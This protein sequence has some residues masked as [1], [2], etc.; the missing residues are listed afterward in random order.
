[1]QRSTEK[2]KRNY[3]AVALLSAAA[4]VMAWAVSDQSRH[5]YWI[6]AAACQVAAVIAVL[7]EG[8][9]SD[10]ASESSDDV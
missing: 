2:A 5:V 10:F 7:R 3:P 8:P 4:A 9:G 1:M 6:W